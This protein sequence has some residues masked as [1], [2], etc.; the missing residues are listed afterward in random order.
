MSTKKRSHKKHS[1]KA[2]LFIAG[3][4]GVVLFWRGMWNL[5]DITGNFI[6]ASPILDNF[7]SLILGSVMLIMSHRLYDEL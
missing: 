6:S 7:L 3:A 2:A 5:V 1:H 4:V